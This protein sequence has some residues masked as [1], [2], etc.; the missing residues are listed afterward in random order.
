MRLWSFYKQGDPTPGNKADAD[1]SLA[2]I[3]RSNLRQSPSTYD[4]AIVSKA[5]NGGYNI[6]SDSTNR[7]N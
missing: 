3:K 7:G 6:F 2:D 4:S 5:S 1:N